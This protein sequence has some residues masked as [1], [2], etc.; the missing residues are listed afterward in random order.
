MTTEPNNHGTGPFLN[1]DQVNFVYNLICRQQVNVA[2]DDFVEVS[3][4]IGGVKTAF[5]EEIHRR[6]EEIVRRNEAAQREAQEEA[7]RLVREA[8]DRVRAEG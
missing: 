2:A 4:M 6:N 7:E 5:V 1:D 8:E 3:S